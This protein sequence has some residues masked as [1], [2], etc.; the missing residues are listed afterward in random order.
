MVIK[1]LVN[2][3]LDIIM[4][5][6]VCFIDHKVIVWV[7]IVNVMSFIVIIVKVILIVI[8]RKWNS[9]I[10]IFSFKLSILFITQSLLF[11]IHYV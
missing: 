11:L 1:L 7:I 10:L 4:F 2:Y 6:L 8:H 3:Q 5:K 9:N